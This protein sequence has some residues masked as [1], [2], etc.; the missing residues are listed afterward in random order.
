MYWKILI[1]VAVDGVVDACVDAA[2][3]PAVPPCR[4]VAD[5]VL[6]SAGSGQVPKHRH[7]VLRKCLY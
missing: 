7:L 2:V 3:D 6:C 1:N 5:Q 4:A